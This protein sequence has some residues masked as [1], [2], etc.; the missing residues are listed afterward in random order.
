MVIHV[1]ALQQSPSVYKQSVG[2]DVASML[3]A[4][5]CAE[6]WHCIFAKR[7]WCDMLVVCST[8]LFSCRGR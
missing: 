5:V 3:Q 6:E 7:A 2:V 8:V 4:K 1:W